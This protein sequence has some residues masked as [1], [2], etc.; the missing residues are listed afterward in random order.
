MPLNQNQLN[1]IRAQMLNPQ[2]TQA[3]VTTNPTQT[4]P[5]IITQATNQQFPQ[6]Q[7]ISPSQLTQLGTQPNQ[8]TFLN[9]AQAQTLA[10]N[11]QQHHQNQQQAQQVQIQQQQAQQLQQQTQQQQHQ[12]VTN[13]S[14]SNN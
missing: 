12:I 3:G 4:Q 11:L 8:I 5:I 1:F 6:T 9:A 10:Q 14:G 7:I 13:Q 2:A